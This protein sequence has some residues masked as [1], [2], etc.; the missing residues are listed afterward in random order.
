MSTIDK[1]YSH[2][3]GCDVADIDIRGDRTPTI[4]IWTNIFSVGDRRELVVRH[5]RYMLMFKGLNTEGMDTTYRKLDE[6]LNESQEIH[7]RL[8]DIK[9]I[10]SL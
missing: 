5:G 2:I 8:E 4:N 7:D 3:M 1:V 10:L 6:C 9:R